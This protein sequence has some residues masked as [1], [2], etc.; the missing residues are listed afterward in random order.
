MLKSKVF[1]SYNSKNA[2][3]SHQEVERRHRAPKRFKRPV[4]RQY[5]FPDNHLSAQFLIVAEIDQ[6]DLAQ[7]VQTK[8]ARPKDGPL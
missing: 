1:V 6:F 7:G 5:T 2:W 4:N 3:S 8:N